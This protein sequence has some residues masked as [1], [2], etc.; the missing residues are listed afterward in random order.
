MFYFYQMYL[1]LKN[2]KVFV[3]LAEQS[4]FS[5]AIWNPM[6]KF[7]CFLAEGTWL[8]NFL[9]GLQKDVIHFALLNIQE[10]VSGWKCC[11]NNPR[12]VRVSLENEVN[13]AAAGGRDFS[14]A[15]CLLSGTRTSRRIHS[16]PDK[17]TEESCPHIKKLNF[18]MFSSELLQRTERRR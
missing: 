15:M 10:Q 17:Y 8:V 16:S 2:I 4:S 14:Q 11:T 12:C 3:C 9:V 5:A 6:Q 18:K 13:P 1:Q 7:L